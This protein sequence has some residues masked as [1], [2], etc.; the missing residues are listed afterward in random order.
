MGEKC[1]GRVTTADGEFRV[2]IFGKL[3][4]EGFKDCGLYVVT[5]FGVIRCDIYLLR[6]GWHSVAVFGIL[7]KNRTG[8]KSRNST[9]NN[10]QNNT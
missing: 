1:C 2:D 7:Y 4:S 9:H 10:T 6:L 8:N 3:L 5:F